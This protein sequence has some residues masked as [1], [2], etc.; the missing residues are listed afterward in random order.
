MTSLGYF[1]FLKGVRVVK[2]VGVEVEMKEYEYEQLVK[3][4]EMFGNNIAFA[5]KHHIF[6]FFLFF[7]LFFFNI[8][9]NLLMLGLKD[10]RVRA[11]RHQAI[12]L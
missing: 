10:I 8:N 7:C 4:L 5:Y 3:T 1:F 12:S 6:L 2:N 9:I 11:V